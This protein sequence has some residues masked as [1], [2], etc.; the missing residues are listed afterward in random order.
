MAQNLNKDQILVRIETVNGVPRVR[1]VTGKE[2]KR[3]LKTHPNLKLPT[4]SLTDLDTFATTLEGMSQVADPTTI[5][6]ANE[7][8]VR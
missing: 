3:F 2:L 7:P 1:Q 5:S 6:V 8:S 4:V